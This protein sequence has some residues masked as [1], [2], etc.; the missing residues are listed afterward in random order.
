MMKFNIGLHGVILIAY[1]NILD[2]FLD[3]IIINMCAL[4]LSLLHSSIFEW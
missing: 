4:F 1:D 2:Y 3:Y